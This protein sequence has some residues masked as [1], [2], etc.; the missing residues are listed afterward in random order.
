MIRRYLQKRN[1]PWELLAIAAL[2]I[3]PGVTLI[4]Q[5]EPIIVVPHVGR[6]DPFIESLSPAGAHIAGWC[7]VALGIFFVILYFY[8]RFAIARDEKAPQPHF[9]DSR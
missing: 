7:A 3:L 5:G 1:N 4:F 8:A 2:F 9:L 6:G